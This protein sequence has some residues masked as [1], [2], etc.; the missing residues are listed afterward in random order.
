[1]F[2]LGMVLFGQ[3]EFARAEECF[4]R[5]CDVRPQDAEAWNNRGVCAHR[6]SRT[7]DAIICFRKALA[8]NPDDQDAAANLQSLGAS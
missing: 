4:A 8:L 3:S 6:L 2:N 5:A 1:L 7:N